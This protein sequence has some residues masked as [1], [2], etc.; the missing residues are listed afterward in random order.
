[1]KIFFFSLLAASSLMAGCGQSKTRAEL[2]QDVV[3]T[4]RALVAAQKNSR[5]EQVISNAQTAYDAAYLTCYPD[6]A[7]SFSVK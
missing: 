3:T 7:Q 5:D 2:L 4:Q 1:M 6:F